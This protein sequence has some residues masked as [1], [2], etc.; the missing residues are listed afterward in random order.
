MVNFGPLDS[1]PER[2]RQRRLYVHNPNV[3]LM[4]TTP[5]ECAE[6]GRITAEK[7]N[8]SQGPVVFLMPLRGVS[9][10]D[11]TG[12]PFDWPE[13]DRS[14]LDALRANLNPRVRLVTLDAHIND[15][16]FAESIANSFLE[17]RN[18]N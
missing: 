14:Y 8:R 3:T 9:A 18:S 12:R 7:L 10:I 5:E 17:L 16:S 4:R 13:A 2:Y 11:A 15:E 1:V 6:L